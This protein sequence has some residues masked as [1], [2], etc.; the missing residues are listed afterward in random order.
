MSYECLDAWKVCHELVLAVYRATDN[1]PEE[2][3]GGCI[4]QLRFAA[5][6]APAKLA[7]GSARTSRKV[8]Q[9]FVELVLGYLAEVAYHLRLSEEQGILP[10]STVRQLSALR[11]RATFYTQKL[12]RSLACSTDAGPPRDA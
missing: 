7:H 11:G 4:E 9:R 8:F 2:Q 12:Y 10:E 5:V 6:L 3:P 1:G